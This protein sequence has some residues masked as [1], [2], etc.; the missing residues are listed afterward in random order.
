M[1]TERECAAVNPGLG[2]P[3][4]VR[5][6]PRPVGGEWRLPV[7]DKGVALSDELPQV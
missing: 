2:V 1:G 5:A 3:G 6:V 7:A 4:D